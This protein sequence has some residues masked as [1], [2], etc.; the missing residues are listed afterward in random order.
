M[1][2]KQMA[3]ALNSG[4]SIGRSSPGKSIRSG[5]YQGRS[6]RGR[7]WV[8]LMFFIF[9]AIDLIFYFGIYKGLGGRAIGL[10]LTNAIWSTALLVGI[11]QRLNW[12]RYVLIALQ[13]R[14]IVVTVIAIVSIQVIRNNYD[15]MILPLVTVAARGVVMG[16]LIGSKDIRRLCSR[17]DG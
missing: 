10:I 6:S 13:I 8:I 9:R 15:F 17:R 14:E 2:S 12:T 4:G 3:N 11:W 1:T 16:L 5:H 7:M